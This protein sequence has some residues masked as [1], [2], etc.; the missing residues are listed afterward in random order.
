MVKKYSQVSGIGSVGDQMRWGNCNVKWSGKKRIL[1]KVGEKRRS[2]RRLS[3]LQK[4]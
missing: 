3:V 2:K 1:L 4:E